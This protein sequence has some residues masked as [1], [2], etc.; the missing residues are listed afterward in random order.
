[1]AKLKGT[2][3]SIKRAEGFAWITHDETGIDHFMHR[4]ALELSTVAFHDLKEDMR[5]EFTPVDAP[6]GPRAIEVR[7]IA[8]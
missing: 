3:K 5:V 1:M 6:K 2:I 8:A 7:V 4:S